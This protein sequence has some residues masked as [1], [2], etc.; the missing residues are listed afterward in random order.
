MIREEYQLREV[1]PGILRC[2]AV[3]CPAMYEGIRNVT[4]EAMLCLIAGCPEVYEAKSSNPQRD[5]C[6]LSA[7]PDIQERGDVYLII[8]KK[9]NPEEA[10]LEKK[11]G[12]GEVLIEVP[13]VLI[14]E[15][16]K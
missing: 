10:G 9:I 3:M 12:E 1:T 13:R 7:C 14:D 11:V 15:R 6:V 4:P 2:A 5:N 8:G 16:E